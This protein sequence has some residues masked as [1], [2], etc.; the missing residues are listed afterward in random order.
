MQTIVPAFRLSGLAVLR[1]LKGL[2]II[3]SAVGRE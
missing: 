2:G 3:V 1:A